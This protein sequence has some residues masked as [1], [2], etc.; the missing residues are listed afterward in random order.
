MGMDISKASLA[1][2]ALQK[3]FESG[4][5]AP[6]ELERRC[7]RTI[8]EAPPKTAAADALV[9][10]LL[11]VGPDAAQQGDDRLA[12]VVVRC[13]A[14]LRQNQPSDD[15]V[16]LVQDLHALLN[17]IVTVPPGWRSLLN[18]PPTRSTRP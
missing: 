5:W 18:R 17:L 11:T 10:G 3:A 9:K 1:L 13:T 12:Q 8:L 4:E 2:A 7:A 14:A 15:R 6:S 16:R